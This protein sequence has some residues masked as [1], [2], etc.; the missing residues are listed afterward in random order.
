MAQPAKEQNQANEKGKDDKIMENKQLSFEV[1]YCANWDGGGQER[2]TAKN[3]ILSVFP[4]AHV[5][6]TKL[7][8]YPIKVTIINKSDNDKIIWTGSQKNLFRKYASKRSQSIEQIKNALQKL[9][10]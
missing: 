9:K 2:D 1:K 5:T 3:T 8:E 4:S 6:T 7:N 10:E